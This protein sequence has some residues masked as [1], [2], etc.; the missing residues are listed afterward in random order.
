MKAVLWD[1][2]GT[3]LYT[4]Q[5]LTNATNATLE[6]FG[7][8]QRT[9]EEVCTF[10]GNG[11]EN[12]MRMA[13][14]EEPENFDEIMAWYRAYYPQHCNET[15][16]VYEGIPEAAKTLLDKGW[17]LAIVSNK[18][19]DATKALWKT[20]FPT[21]TA[22]LGQKPPLR[23]KP[24]PDMVLKTMEELGITKA[25]YVGDSDVDV[26]TA[27][28]AG[29][30]CISAL[31]GYRSKEVLEEAGATCFAQK[32]TDIPALAQELWEQVYGA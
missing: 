22:A 25:I 7:Y 15:T 27:K 20:Y 4:L 3:L 19:D 26:K 31:W 32:P 10:V 30:P 11:A 5:D 18:P 24:F 1:L 29:L 6:A 17:K 13:L 2:D 8:P 12:Q 16:K 23:R 9:L 21:F 28:A 14:G